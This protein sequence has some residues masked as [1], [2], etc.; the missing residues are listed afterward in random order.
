MIRHIRMLWTNAH[1]HKMNGPR[2]KAGVCPP[3][4]NYA[5]WRDLSTDMAIAPIAAKINPRQLELSLETAS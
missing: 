1:G 4:E 2:R 3:V 5:L